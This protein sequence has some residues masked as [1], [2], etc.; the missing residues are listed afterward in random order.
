MH[1]YVVIVRTSPLRGQF[2]WIRAIL[3][4][5]LKA[6]S[7]ALHT[8]IADVWVHSQHPSQ[9]SFRSVG[10][11]LEQGCVIGRD[12]PHATAR[13]VPS[14]SSSIYSDQ[15]NS[16]YGAYVLVSV[17]ERDRR[18]SILRDPTG[19]I[20]CWRI[21]LPDVDVLFSHYDDVVGLDE[22][23]ADISWDFV[24]YHLNNDMMR[25]EETGLDR[26]TEVVP[27]E[28]IT[29]VDGTARKQMQWRP[30]VFASDPYR[31]IDEATVAIRTAAAQVVCD[32]S[33][34]YRSLAIDVSGGLDSAILLGLL[35]GIARHENVIGVNYVIPHAEGDE[36]D[37]ARVVA[38]R[39][40]IGLIEDY[41]ALE[42][43]DPIPSFSR[44]LMRPAIR[45]MPLGYDQLS[46]S[47]LRN[48]GAEA[49]M[50]GSAGDQMFYDF[51]PTTAAADYLNDKGMSGFVAAAHHLAKLSRD[52]IW[53]AFGAA[54][55]YRAGRTPTLRE[56]LQVY[57]PLL[58][59]EAR[60]AADYNR[61]GPTWIKE[62][63]AVTPP[64]KLRQ[65][66]TFCELNRHYW[67]YGRAD[68]AE[69]IH[70]LHSQP[71]MEASLRTPAYWFGLGGLQRGLARDAFGDLLPDEIRYRRSKGANTSHWVQVLL[72]DLKL[73]RE[74]LLD[75]A[76]MARGLL[77]RSKVEA[78]LTPATIAEGAAFM[79]LVICLTTEMWIRQVQVDRGSARPEMRVMSG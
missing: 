10:D 12:F 47:I 41:P 11:G 14:S 60:E 67:R 78:A 26:I 45:T 17:N 77:D 57:N 29:Y 68:A 25:G 55:A 66:F 21:C 35:R 62:A 27:G 1:R 28:A 16:R 79:P 50:T 53:N 2:D 42:N 13:P 30:H 51:L 19:R 9:L 40:G 37:F 54:I 59:T 23:E 56:L 33:R 24:T 34:R 7:K 5:R 8:G 58:T 36:R 64:A 32:W 38:H 20:E 3:G 31:S 76:L 6:W 39:N 71:V 70:P 72:R 75:G 52:T 61:F 73:N 44:R 49:F 74:L 22:V 65:I 46:A 48:V 69:E 43:G 4:E 15:L 63:A 18:V